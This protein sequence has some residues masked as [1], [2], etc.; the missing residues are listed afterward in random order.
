MDLG[1]E[2]RNTDTER[3]KGWQGK[4]GALAQRILEPRKVGLVQSKNSQGRWCALRE[5]QAPP[6]SRGGRRWLERTALLGVHGRAFQ[7]GTGL[8]GK[9]PRPRGGTWSSEEAV[10]PLGHPYPCP[11]LTAPSPT[12]WHGG[13]AAAA[14]AEGA[15]V[16]YIHAAALPAVTLLSAMHEY[17]LNTEF[18]VTI[19]PRE[20][21]DL[22]WDGSP[23]SGC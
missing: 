17:Y 23:P 3:E 2:R 21:R 9:G 12:L 19:L 1:R 14:A 7:P 18:V 16:I 5:P 22:L 8:K 4:E 6:G 13:E 10:P 15:K 11:A 20:T